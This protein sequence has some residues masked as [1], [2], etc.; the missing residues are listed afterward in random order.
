MLSA[1]RSAARATS[2]LPYAFQATRSMAMSGVKGF[3]EHEQAV[4]NMYFSKEDERLMSKLL[5][6]M[7]KQTSV[8]DVSAATESAVA[9]EAALRNIV[10]KYQMSK[11]DFKALLDWKHAH[12]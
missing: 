2:S 8:T 11:D 9:E 1:A 4:E 7:K 5:S 10:A 3:N 6:K 12:Y